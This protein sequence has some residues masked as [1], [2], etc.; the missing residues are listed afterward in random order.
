MTG[1]SKQPVTIPNLTDNETYLFRV[2]ASN[3]SGTIIYTGQS[4]ALLLPGSNAV[5]LTCYEMNG[6]DA[7]AGS[8]FGSDSSDPSSVDTF[9]INPS[10][11]GS[12]TSSTSWS[13]HLYL[14]ATATSGIYTVNFFTRDSSGIIEAVGT[15]TLNA[16]S[17]SASG[18]GTKPSTGGS[19]TW[20]L[21]KG[22][23]T[24]V[25]PQPQPTVGTPFLLAS[26]YKSFVLDTGTAN[27]VYHLN[28]NATGVPYALVN[29][30][31]PQA[32]TANTASDRAP[33]GLAR[34][35]NGYLIAWTEAN[36]G[37]YYIMGRLLD[38]SGAPTGSPFIIDSSAQPQEGAIQTAFDG[39]NYLVIRPQ[40]ATLSTI[41]I[42]GRYVNA[43]GSVVNS[44]TIASGISIEN[45]D[46]SLIFAAGSYFVVTAEGVSPSYNYFIRSVST[47]G[48]TSAAVQL[49]TTATIENQYPSSI[50][51]DGTN[52][53]VITPIS[54]VSGV[55]NLYGR[56]V[57]TAL[58]PQGA[59]FPITT[60]TTRKFGGWP[61]FDGSNFLV[62]YTDFGATSAAVYGQRISPAGALVGTPFLI[63]NNAT[64]SMCSYASASSRYQCLYHT[65]AT[66]V[67]SP[68]TMFN[69]MNNLYGVTV[70]P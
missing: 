49:N 66:Y 34:G 50:G 48:V 11:I 36:A 62:T 7:V 56:R 64:F 70:Q 37:T 57:S 45:S 25:P 59:E 9:S 2:V 44:V 28:N 23:P 55:V 32:L 14:S 63:A 27:T 46:V 4:T 19:S 8:Y 24:P 29:T 52:L 51:F 69:N 21:T 16:S 20:T 53:L 47:A 42:V 31:T 3:N 15:G 5:N 40:Q 43:S 38:P 26:G 17:G 30:G 33:L 65:Y 18:N 54:T 67:Q 35:T 61:S 39:S 12:L 13:M 41:N 58:V 60:G 68:Q 22:S 6:F 10:G 1:S